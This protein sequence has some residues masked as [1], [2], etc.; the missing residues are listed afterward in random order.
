MKITS[1]YLTMGTVEA[2]NCLENMWYI[3]RGKPIT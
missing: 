3:W 2:L 1:V